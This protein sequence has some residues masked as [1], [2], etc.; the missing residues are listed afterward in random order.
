MV[1]RHGWFALSSVNYEANGKIY[2]LI[3]KGGDVSRITTFI[4]SYNKS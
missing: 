2:S 4:S 3:H 1:A